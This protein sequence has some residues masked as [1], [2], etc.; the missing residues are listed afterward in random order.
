MRRLLPLLL[1]LALAACQV[2]EQR[3]VVNRG[4]DTARWWDKLPR[5]EWA[6]FERLDVGKGWFEIY[7]I[8]PH[9]IALYEPGQFEEVISFLV[10]GSERALLFDS[11]MGIGDIRAEVEALTE[12]P[13]IVLN[14]HTHY[15]HTGGNWQFA[16]LWGRDTPYS[17]ERMA[18]LGHSEV[19]EAVSEGWIWKPLPPGFDRDSYRLRPWQ[20]DRFVDEGLQIDLGGVSLEVI[21]SPGHSPDSISLLDRHNRLLFTG[22]T[23][24]LAP[25]YMHIE[26]GSFNDYRASASKLA[27]LSP[28]VD[29]LLTSHNVP[30]ASGKYLSALHA[31]MESIA[32]GSDNFEPID[33]AREYPFDGFSVIT[34]DPPQRAEH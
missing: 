28:E 21:Y 17:R 7:R 11:G 14:S 16:T 23:F 13:V 29:E 12:L 19:A 3:Q 34:L 32:A 18:G 31:A 8:K 4:G 25:L 10:L 15:D 1:A 9:I 2:N 30:V 20:F 27:A 6:A 26:G 5:V 24:Y 22:D 33:G